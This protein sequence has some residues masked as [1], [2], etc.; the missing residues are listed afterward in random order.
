MGRWQ[1]IFPEEA[2]AGLFLEG[3]RR[4]MLGCGLVQQWHGGVVHEIDADGNPLLAAGHAGDLPISTCSP[5]APYGHIRQ[6][7]VASIPASP[8]FVAIGSLCEAAV[9]VDMDGL[10]HDWSPTSPDHYL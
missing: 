7:M 10:L 5:P 4:R 8:P 2:L 1:R 9:T 6:R 3:W